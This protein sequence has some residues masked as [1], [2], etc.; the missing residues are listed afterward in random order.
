MDEHVLLHT[1]RIELM[2]GKMLL[3]NIGA[4]Q[5]E[6]LE[7]WLQTRTDDLMEF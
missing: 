7:N 3:Y 5:K 1:L 4:H 2:N 6:E